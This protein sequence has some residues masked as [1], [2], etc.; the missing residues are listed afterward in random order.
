MNQR[1]CSRRRFENRALTRRAFLRG[2]EKAER[3]TELLISTGT[4]TRNIDAPPAGGCVVSVKAKLDGDQEV[5][6]SL[7]YHQLFFYGDYCRELED[8]APLLDLQAHIV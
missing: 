5:L 2:D 8:F 7:D 3:N 4:V 6:T 1:R